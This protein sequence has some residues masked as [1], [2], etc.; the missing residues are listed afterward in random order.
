MYLKSWVSHIWVRLRWG[1]SDYVVIAIRTNRHIY[2]CGIFMCTQWSHAVP[3]APIHST[4]AYTYTKFRKTSFALWKWYYT[5][6][7]VI[8]F[9]LCSQYPSPNLFFQITNPPYPTHKKVHLFSSAL[10]SHL[11]FLPRIRNPGDIKCFGEDRQKSEI[12]NIALLEL[13]FI[14]SFVLRVWARC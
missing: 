11:S 14:V 2:V 9:A 8:F 13:R 6:L 7:S 12:V 1:V 4:H 5:I 10:R 3:F